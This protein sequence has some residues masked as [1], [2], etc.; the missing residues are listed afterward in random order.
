MSES[1]EEAIADAEAIVD[2]EDLPELNTDPDN[3]PD[4]SAE[5]IVGET[6]DREG[7]ERPAQN[8]HS[9]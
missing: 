9:E 8:K 3:D 5:Y 7:T 4:D 6:Q 1:P 2:D